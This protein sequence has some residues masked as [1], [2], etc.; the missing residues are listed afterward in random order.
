M[1]ARLSLGTAGRARVEVCL[2]VWGSGG[3]GD[4]WEGASAC[5]RGSTCLRRR[6]RAPAQLVAGVCAGSLCAWQGGWVWL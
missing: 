2:E 1:Q 5:V 3:R 4:G 6:G